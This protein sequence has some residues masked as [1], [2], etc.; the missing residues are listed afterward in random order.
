MEKSNYPIGNLTCDLPASST[1]S[2]R[3]T[4]LHAP[5]YCEVRTGFMNTIQKQF[6]LE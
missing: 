3:N 2:E 4:L 1:L 6:D 5:V